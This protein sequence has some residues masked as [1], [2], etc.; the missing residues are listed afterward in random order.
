MTAFPALR[1]GAIAAALSLALPL[2]TGCSST[3]GGGPPPPD[4]SL[5]VDGV[6]VELTVEPA[7][8]P[9]GGPG[10]L[11]VEI[12]NTTDRE[13]RIAFPD[14]KQV[15]LI[16]FE[17]DTPYPVDG[18]SVSVPKYLA[19]GPLESWKHSID[20]DGGRGGG[21]R[22]SPLLPGSYEL[23]V[24]LRRSGDTYINH[25]NRV[26]VEIVE[27]AEGGEESAP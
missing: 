27:A 13:V 16:V 17:N 6:D 25:S 22:R 1:L 24:A 9:A 18:H 5:D 10:T 20:W 23:Q 3:S 15:G 12:F 21:E 7:R 14:F 26:A 2:A 8:I 11:H 4:V 19:L